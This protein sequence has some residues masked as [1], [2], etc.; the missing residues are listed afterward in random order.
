MDHEVTTLLRA[1]GSGDQTVSDQLFHS[2]YD[3]LRSLAESHLRARPDATIGPTVLI[4]EAFLQLA[5][6]PKDDWRDRAQ[7]FAFTATVM[8]R[9]MSAYARRRNADKRSN[10]FEAECSMSR[11]TPCLSM[12]S[13]PP[14]ST[15]L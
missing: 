5:A 1:W 8:R 4:H 15:K 7:F 12:A 13:T 14:I 3:E 9:L 2:T 10:G 11:S 6:D